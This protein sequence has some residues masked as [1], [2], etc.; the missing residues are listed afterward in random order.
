MWNKVYNCLCELSNTE[1]SCDAQVTYS[2][3]IMMVHLW[4][5]KSWSLSYINFSSS[6]SWYLSCKGALGGDENWTCWG[7][8]SSTREKNRKTLLNCVHPWACKSPCHVYLIAV[9][10]NSSD[11]GSSLQGQSAIYELAPVSQWHHGYVCEMEAHFS[12]LWK[13]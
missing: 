4:K 7:G 2:S 1:S 6:R 5:R 11:Q 10:L 9:S 13:M 12:T 8:C 3:T